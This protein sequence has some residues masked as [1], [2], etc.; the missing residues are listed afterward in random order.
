MAGKNAV[1]SQEKV[2]SEEIS[3]QK[4]KLQIDQHKIADKDNQLQELEKL[5]NKKIVSLFIILVIMLLILFYFVYQNNKLKQKIKRKEIRQKIQLDIINASIDAQENERKKIAGFLHDNINSLLS[6]VGMH[7]N[8]FSVHNDIKSNELLKAKS[9][10]E[11]AHDRLRDMSH[12]LIPALLVRFGLVYALEDLC[13]K[14]SNSGLQFEFSSSI[15]PEMRYN[16]K[17][18]MKIYFI[19]AELFNNIIKHSGANKAELSL[20]EKQNLLII[21]IKDNGK[22]FKTDK[23]KD[24]EGFGLNRIRARIKKYKGNISITSKVNEGT[25]IKIKV[26]AIH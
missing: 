18:E 21:I 17:I 10:L 14:N 8:A 5:T 9:I 26:P 19:V 6:S 25:S 13:E 16:E 12:E 1:F 4:S 22:G 23:L 3:I 20:N 2:F 15:D 7:L 24:V 11:D